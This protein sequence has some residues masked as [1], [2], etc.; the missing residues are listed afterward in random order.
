[1]FEINTLWIL[2]LSVQR[3]IDERRSVNSW[4]R[5]GEWSRLQKARVENAD[6]T[7]DSDALPVHEWTQITTNVGGK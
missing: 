6:R 7:K 3:R 2:K 1:M 4:M 5:F